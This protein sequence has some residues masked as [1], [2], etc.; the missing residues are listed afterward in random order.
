MCSGFIVFGRADI[1]GHAPQMCFYENSIKPIGIY[2]GLANPAPALHHA[3]FSD[4]HGSF[5]TPHEA[6]HTIYYKTTSF[7]S[8]ATSVKVT[9]SYLKNKCN[10]AM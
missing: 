6:F 3:F 10:N 8:D 9:F 1:Y 2:I 7:H 5:G 4:F